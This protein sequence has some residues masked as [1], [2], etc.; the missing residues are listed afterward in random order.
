M[1]KQ[2]TQIPTGFGTKP[3]QAPTTTSQTPQ[4]TAYVPG[5]STRTFGATGYTSET[6]IRADV[7][8]ILKLPIPK[9][10]AKQLA[11]TG[12]DM[13][14]LLLEQHKKASKLSDEERHAIAEKWI[15]KR[16]ADAKKRGKLMTD[17][18]LSDWR[19]GRTF[20]VGDRAKYIGLERN[21][22]TSLGVIPRPTGQVG[23]II[24]VENEKGHKIIVF[25]PDEAVQVI[26]G[27]DRHIVN[28]QVRENTTG[29]LCLERIPV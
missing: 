6:E 12:I 17:I 16:V 3:V 28:L 5:L 14:P 21:E 24:A 22:V 4:A 20:K 25:E 9:V 1:T 18:Q 13:D 11:A 26:D 2:K 10:N 23:T 15:L 27:E 7:A 8:D 19:L 29:W